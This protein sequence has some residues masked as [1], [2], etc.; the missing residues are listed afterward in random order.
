M[1]EPPPGVRRLTAMTPRHVLLPLL[2]VAALVL[3]ASPAAASCAA[4]ARA[5]EHAFVGTV[6]TT[7]SR[8]RVAVVRTEDG[9]TVEVRGGETSAAASS[10]DRTYEVGGRYEFHPVNDASPYQDN[11][12]TRTRL[13]EHGAA[14][15]GAPAEGGGGGSS[16]VLRYVAFGLSSVVAAVVLALAL[17]RR[18]P[19]SA[20]TA[21]AP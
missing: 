19:V 3:P 12:C 16:P 6:L 21:T 1:V 2:V 5:S 20:Q 7:T 14:P 18:R 17:R 4:P 10:V 15:A 13:L 8:G 9:R 11:A